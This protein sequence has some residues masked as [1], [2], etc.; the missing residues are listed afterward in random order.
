MGRQC[1]PC[2][3]KRRRLLLD[4][5]AAGKRIELAAHDAGVSRR[6][7]FNWRSADPSLAEEWDQ[8]YDQATDKL[9]DVLYRKALEGDLGSL[10]F[11]LRSR[12][13]HKY[14]PALTARLEMLALAKARA[15]AD[16]E[17]GGLTI[18]TGA[19]AMIYPVQARLETPRLLGT[20][21]VDAAA[22]EGADTDTPDDEEVAA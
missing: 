13:P 3:P 1:T 11:A 15:V 16:A 2:T 6:T 10:V 14:N 21:A 22:V 9:E 7:A 4:A 12:M 8:A 17:V 5:I 18:E 20:V 19:A